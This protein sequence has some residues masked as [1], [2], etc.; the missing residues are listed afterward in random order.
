MIDEAR[1]ELEEERD[2]LLRSIDDLDAEH[3]AGD[4]ADDDYTRLRDD[5]TARAA[6]VLRRL[7]GDGAGAD[8]RVDVPD[9]DSAGDH[10][11]DAD[12]D[13]TEEPV[14]LPARARAAR[15]RRRR[16]TRAVAISL[17]VLLLGVGA[18]VTLALTAG[19]RSPGE[20]AT[21]SLPGST[22]DRITKAQQLVSDGK[23]LDAVKLYDAVLKDDPNNPIALAQRGWLISR[24]DASLADIGMQNIDEALSIDPGYAEAHF[25]KGM[26]LWQN[27]KDPAGAADEF[28]KA[29][30]AGAPPDLKT[31]LEQERDQSRAEANGVPPDQA[32]TSTT[33]TP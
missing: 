13:A 27:K 2:F 15:P 26:L 1:R 7:D 29:I 9:A 19:E 25:F 33:T 16:R 31:F 3:D 23:V 12:E 20:A 11:A 30:D 5:Y 28:Q 4:L 10:E 24:V 17:V 22:E 32:A 14:V 18:G 6:A 21:G 8:G